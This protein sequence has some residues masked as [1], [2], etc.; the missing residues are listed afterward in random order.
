MAE[1]TARR[2]LSAYRLRLEPRLDEPPAWFSF[3]LSLVAIIVA[4]I[5]GGIVIAAAGGDPIRSYVH[6][7]NASFGSIGVLSDTIV[8]ATPIL[9]AALACCDRLPHAALE[10]WRRGAVHHGSFR[11]ERHHPGSRAAGGDIWL[12]LHPGHDPGGHGRGCG[13]GFHPGISQVGIQCQ[14]NHQ[15]ADAQLHRRGV[16][17]LLDLCGMDRGRISDEPHLPQDGL[18][19]QAAGLRRERAGSFRV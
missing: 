11:R 19:S 16:G 9:L 15:L 4:L 3:L 13:L 12:D 6:I 17:Q 18:A 14:R 1:A 2:R 8:K 7:A 10:Y 5:V